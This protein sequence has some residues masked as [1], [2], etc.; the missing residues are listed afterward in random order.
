MPTSIESYEDLN[1]QDLGASV[2]EIQDAAKQSL[3]FLAALAMPTI[4]KY[5]YPDI[6][7]S[8]WNWLISFAHQSRV[9]P[10]LA[11]GLPRGFGKTT[12]IKIFIL[13][14]ILFTNKKFILVV[15]ASA[16]MAENIIADVTDMLNE[17]N[18][19]KVF[20]DWK[21]G[22]EKDTQ[23]VKKF[24][25]R[26]RNVILAAIGVGGSLRGLN[27]KNERPDVMLFD[28]IQK[29]EDAD[30]E[31]LAKN[32]ED[33]LLATAM[34]A[35]SPHGC[36]FLFLAN[37]YPTEH[38]LLRKIKHNSQWTK[39]IV[40]GILEDGTS[41]WEELQPI[42]QLLNEFQNDLAHN[43]PE[44]FYAEVLN[45]ENASVNNLLNISQL[46][47]VPFQEGDIHA[48]NFVIIDPATDKLGSDAVAVGY[49]E[50][51]DSYPCMMSVIADRLSPGE[52]I[53][54]ALKFCLEKNCRLIAVE[55]NAY[56]YTFLYWFN[57]ICQQLGISGIEC[58]DIY[59]GNR[60]KPHRILQM[61]KAWRAGEIFI[62]GECKA[63][64][65]SEVLSFNPLRRD[66]KDNILDLM[67]YAP[68]VV[69]EYGEFIVIN[70]IIESQE[71]NTIDVQEYNTAF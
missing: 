29:R 55:S 18:I 64:T 19:K 6:F 7:L 38:S 34:K 30:S 49:F 32:L 40:G 1:V 3:N 9:F 28:D 59:S 56:Q 33:W 63:L 23:A 26:G 15:A 35:K 12:F 2:K 53:R 21:V 50:V 42:T 61:F 66:N 71:F 4:F 52:T 62:S 24:G 69:D 46:P 16:T 22:C 14:C 54:A 43:R 27:L 39:F 70:T 44:I 31:I 17:P 57:F 58:V 37:M 36:M 60:S 65:Y 5:L 20:G 8:A 47:A 45:D 68:R 48:G 41:L 11:L 13:Y 10:Q 25:Y 51:Y 67:T